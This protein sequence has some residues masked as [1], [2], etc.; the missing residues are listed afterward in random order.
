MVRRPPVRVLVFLGDF[1]YCWV[2]QAL[3][4]NLTAQGATKEQAVHNLDA[5]I[6]HNAIYKVPEGDLTWV[7]PEWLEVAFWGGLPFDV[8][9]CGLTVRERWP[10]P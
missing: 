8:G 6:M 3:E 2:A 9:V 1:G 7:T 5:T 10:E 4:F